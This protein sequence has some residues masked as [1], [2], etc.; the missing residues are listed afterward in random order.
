MPTNLA[1]DEGLS[2][3]AKKLDGFRTKKETVNA[4]LREFIRQRDQKEILKLAGTIEFRD[5]WDY[6]KDRQGRAHRH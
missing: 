6:S 1:I 5:D 2:N 4:A 3:K